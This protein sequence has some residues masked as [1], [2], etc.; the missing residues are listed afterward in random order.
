MSACALPYYDRK[1]V[2]LER[3]VACAGCPQL[4]QRVGGVWW[5][6]ERREKLYSRK[7]LLE[8]FRWCP[9]AQRIWESERER[10]TG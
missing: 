3:G 10:Q 6:L 5:D 4:P 7:E 2:S 9:Q 1:T 8:H